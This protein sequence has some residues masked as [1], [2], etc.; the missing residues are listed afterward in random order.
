MGKEK[1]RARSARRGIEN[2]SLTPAVE[3][4]G[5]SALQVPPLRVDHSYMEE[6]LRRQFFERDG[7]TCPFDSSKV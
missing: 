7:F 2:L 6:I 3:E 1:R 5:P 4:L